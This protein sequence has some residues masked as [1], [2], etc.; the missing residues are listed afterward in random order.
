MLSV[1]LLPSNSEIL[2]LDYVSTLEKEDLLIVCPSPVK[3][4]GTR[5]HIQATGRLV[6]VVTIS[7][8][9]KEALSLL[10]D[11]APQISRKSDLLLKLSTIWKIKFPGFE[12]DIFT[13]AFNL[14]T[15]LRGFSLNLEM[16]EDV[17]EEEEEKMATAVRFFWLVAEELNLHDEH[18]SY[19]ILAEEL[20]SMES[21]VHES[22]K[23]KVIVFLGFKHLSGGQLDLLKSLGIRAEVFVPIHQEIYKNADSLSWISWLGE[24]TEEAFGK[25]LEKQALEVFRFKKGR[26][27][28]ESYLKLNEI[29]QRG[30]EVLIPTSTQSFQELNVLPVEDL[31]F[32]AGIDP[33]KPILTT[34]TTELKS[35]TDFGSIELSIEKVKEI[36]NDFDGKSQ[37]GDYFFR[38]L[39]VKSLYLKLLEDWE[40][41]SEAN[42][43]FT[44]FDAEVFYEILDLDLPRNYLIPLFDS[45]PSHFL[46][47]LDSA[48]LVSKKEAVLIGGSFLGP[49]KGGESNFS[50]IQLDS[51]ATL[52]PIRSS[53]LDFLTKKV[54]F[55]DLASE[56]KVSLFLEKDFEETDLS[57]LEI[58]EEF[59]TIDI[60]LQSEAVEKI[61]LI[62]DKTNIANF[63]LEK[64]SS[65]S[66]Q[67]YLDCPRKFY[68][69]YIERVDLE[70]H[71]SERL[72][73]YH[74]GIIEHEV[75]GQYFKNRDIGLEEIVI[76]ELNKVLAK[77][78]LTL[79]Q[80]QYQ[81]ALYEINL[82]A[83]RGIKFVEA[84][85]SFF[86]KGDFEFESNFEHTLE[87]VKH[88][89]SIDFFYQNSDTSVIIDFKRSAAGIPAVGK[90]KNH[91]KLQ[92]W[93]YLSHCGIDSASNALIGYFNLKDP[94]A[95]LLFSPDKETAKEL[96][97][98]LTELSVRVGHLKDYEDLT[99]AYLIK[100]K[101]LIS[102]LRNEKEYLAKPL[103]SSS[104]SYCPVENI[105]DRGVL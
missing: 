79:N 10:G 35:L 102:D 96:T 38:F 8:F 71:L 57:W 97:R 49:L 20:R 18:S 14:Y 31:F 29:V 6:D 4:D 43:S 55:K 12:Y 40:E 45:E 36:L 64:A 48:E 62:S 74:L 77:E 46:S 54:A 34:I 67:T 78:S 44:F 56:V 91:E 68:Y 59:E 5:A 28:E 27:S 7:K 73:S 11:E 83:N 23:G 63:T 65:T 16:L 101:K 86:G 37:K 93:Y 61:N 32:K 72:Q 2:K 98:F 33:F 90:F 69:N 92:A 88:R 39:K 104:C 1:K 51:L 84:I 50:D 85:N 3:A 82:Y 52:G 30:A 100:E 76:R 58:L 9:I 99:E 22:V 13:K 17:L 66:L 25:N 41:L 53:E 26:F 94:S 87:Q 19:G 15:E 60:N 42:D 81:E 95:S 24:N 70:A 47:S 75:I 21:P 80:V 89:G 105:C 103:D